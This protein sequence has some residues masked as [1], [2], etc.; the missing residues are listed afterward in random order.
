[1]SQ[2]I[3][4]QQIVVDR[5]VIIMGRYRRNVLV[6]GMLDRC[7][8]IDI[9]SDRQHNDSSR[10][11]TGSRSNPGA[12]EYQAIDLASS[13]LLVHRVKIFFYIPVG[14]LIR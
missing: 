14:S 1:M 3:Q 6:G 9:L 7:K 4:L 5:V 10:M 11:L 8:R 2:N 12:L 13:L